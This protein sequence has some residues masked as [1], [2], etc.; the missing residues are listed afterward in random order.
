ME[1]IIFKTKIDFKA[2]E[3]YRDHDK[4]DL[5]II[6]F[7]SLYRAIGLLDAAQKYKENEDPD[8]FIDITNK[9]NIACNLATQKLLKSFIENNWSIYSIDIDANEHVFWDTTKFPKGKKHYK[10]KLKAVVRNAVKLDYLKHCPGL[11]DSLGICEIVLKVELPDPK[12]ESD[13]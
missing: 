2:L 1:K 3:K 10:K 5:P 12:E 4:D 8:F 6:G 7:I 13:A 9:S 11:D